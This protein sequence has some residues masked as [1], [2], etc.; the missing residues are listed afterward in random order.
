MS[1]Y[2]NCKQ[3]VCF[4]KTEKLSPTLKTRKHLIL[5]VRVRSLKFIF[6]LE[7]LAGNLFTGKCTFIYKDNIQGA[8]KAE[9]VSASLERTADHAFRTVNIK[10]NDSKE[11]LDSCHKFSKIFS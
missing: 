9:R 5:H 11:I 3:A 6:S 10:L 8:I 4:K 1:I 7:P 2:G